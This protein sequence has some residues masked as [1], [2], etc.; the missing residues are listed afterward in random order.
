MGKVL[1]LET[2]VQLTS[3]SQLSL[4]LRTLCFMLAVYSIYIAFK[5][6]QNSA[7]AIAVALSV[8]MGV[9]LVLSYGKIFGLWV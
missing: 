7:V 1:A 5:K 6:S 2:A 3:I 8:G 9:S 4:S